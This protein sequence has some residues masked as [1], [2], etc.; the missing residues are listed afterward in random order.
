MTVRIS[1]LILREI[2]DFWRVAL[3]ISVISYP[4]VENVD[5][6]RNQQDELQQ[7][8]EKYLRVQRSITDLGKVSNNVCRNCAFPIATIP[9]CHVHV[10]V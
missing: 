6:T 5:D 9:K 3:F 1:G 10:T 7:R 8:K 4:K 2:K